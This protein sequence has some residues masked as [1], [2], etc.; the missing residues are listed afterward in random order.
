MKAMFRE[1]LPVTPLT[2]TIHISPT[3]KTD[4]HPPRKV[5]VHSGLVLKSRSLSF[6]LGLA[7]RCETQSGEVGI[8]GI[9]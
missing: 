8:R 5:S 3:C 1:D 7:V 6:K 9:R 4:S 2:T